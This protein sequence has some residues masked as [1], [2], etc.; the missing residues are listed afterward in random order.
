MKRK[1]LKENKER[2]KTMNQ[3]DCSDLIDKFMNS[4]PGSVLMKEKNKPKLYNLKEKIYLVI[5]DHE[6]KYIC[7]RNTWNY[8][9]YQKLRKIRDSPDEYSFSQDPSFFYLRKKV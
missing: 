9:F 1:N 3:M 4:I 5:P 6:E 8:D 7:W 2:E